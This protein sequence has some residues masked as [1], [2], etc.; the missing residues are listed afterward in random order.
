M[1]SVLAF[2]CGLL[3]LVASILLIPK[4]CSNLSLAIKTHGLNVYKDE[5]FTAHL[6]AFTVTLFLI[7]I[8]MHGLGIGAGWATFNIVSF[9]MLLLASTTLHRTWPIM[10]SLVRVVKKTATD[11]TESNATSGKDQSTTK[12][13]SIQISNKDAHT[14]SRTVSRPEAMHNTDRTVLLY[15]WRKENYESDLEYV[16][17][18][19]DLYLVQNS[20]KW[21]DAR[22]GDAVYA[23]S[24]RDDGIYCLVASYEI[25]A[26]VETESHYGQWMALSKPGTSRLFDPTCG[27]DIEPLIRQLPLS[28][29]NP[30]LGRNFQG[31]AAVKHVPVGYEDLLERFAQAQPLLDD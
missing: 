11:Y 31:P 7:A 26:V 5:S 22:T 20:H 10:I 6:Q 14:A 8:G 3:G 2:F 30:S 15:H 23:I 17:S 4:L 9:L 19:D 16:E 12:T 18:G 21:R 28:L 25:E 27:Q 13:T 1:I 29:K 24:R